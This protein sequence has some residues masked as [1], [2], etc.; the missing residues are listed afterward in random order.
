MLRSERSPNGAF[1]VTEFGSVADPMQFRALYAYSPYHHVTDGV[2]YPRVLMLTGEN[3]PR[4]DPMQSRKMIARLQASGAGGPFLL[5]TSES[6]GHGGG[7][8]LSE[9]IAQTTDALSFMLDGL[10]A[11]P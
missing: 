2:V 1:N 7:S 8:D 10:G 4:V 11:A 9:I 3:D 6:A 5:R